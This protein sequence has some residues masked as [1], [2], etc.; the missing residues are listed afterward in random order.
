MA[1]QPLLDLSRFFCFLIM[2]LPPSFSL[3]SY[4]WSIPETQGIGT[5]LFTAYVTTLS[6]GLIL[7]RW[8]TELLMNSELERIWKEAVLV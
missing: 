1:L 4:P 6:V 8:M 5:Y 7:Q 2:Q 3:T